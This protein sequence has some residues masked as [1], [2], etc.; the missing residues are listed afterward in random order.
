M[1]RNRAETI[2]IIQ[3]LSKIVKSTG[4]LQFS[5]KTRAGLSEADKPD[6]LAFLQ[7]IAPYCD[8][9]SIHGRTLK[10]GYRGD[11]DFEFIQQ[12]KNSV[13]TPVFANGGIQ[14]YQHA[15]ELLQNYPFD[16][17]MIG[18]KAI[19]NPWIFTPHEPSKAELFATIFQHVRLLI[20]CDLR[21]EEASQKIKDYYFPQPSLEDLE[22]L[23]N[24]I[25]PEREYRGVVEF[26]KHLFQYIKGIPDS[27]EWKQSIIPIKTL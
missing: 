27:R 26:R 12:V 7:N 19:G 16:G 21:F 11:A 17:I 13:S 23:Q 22:Q 10:Q 24:Q 25:D 20:T 1:L 8:R 6:Q 14:N 4:T 15:Q 3:N 9:I 18:Q 5:I 2:K